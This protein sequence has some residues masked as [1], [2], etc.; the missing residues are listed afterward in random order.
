MKAILSILLLAGPLTWAQ[1][2]KEVGSLV[3]EGVPEIPAALADRLNQYQ[4]TRSASFS[5]WFPDGKSMLISTRFAETAQ[6][7]VVEMPGGARK[8]ITFFKEPIGGGSFSPNAKYKGFM[9]TKDVGGNE[10]RQ[11]HWFDLTN[12][13]YQMLS[14]G[15]RTQNST[16]SWS[17][18]GDQF[19]Y[20]STRRNLKDYDL[21]LSSMAN[22]KDAK[23]ILQQGGS[24]APADWSPD[25]TKVIVRNYISAN[26]SYGYVLD[27][28]CRW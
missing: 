12:G 3:V 19:I 16:P 15:G 6:L 17:N 26:R 4:N 20:V 18:R 2:A 24:W 10:F 13:S 23:I 9:F 22:P 5:G 11:L 21:Y 7:H 25:D 1:T 14:D 27:M 8:Q 28:V